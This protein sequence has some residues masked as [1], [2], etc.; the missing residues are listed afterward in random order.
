MDVWEAIKKRR[1]IRKY[2]DKQVP[3]SAI[4]KLIEAARLAPSGCNVQPWK[5]MIVTNESV[6]EKLKMGKAFN[7][8]FVYTAPV[9]I[10]CC[11]DQS[12]Y[13]G[14]T[15]AEYQIMEGSLP[16]NEKTRK[17]WFNFLKQKRDF[18]TVRDITIAASFMILRAEE[19]GLS[20]CFVALI[21]EGIIKDVLKIPK[22]M[23]I[24]YVITV[25]Y[26][27]E[28]PSRRPRKQIN[29]IIR[30]QEGKRVNP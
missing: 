16:R 18:R 8:N 27:A 22:R 5:F 11:G 26:A 23:L 1:S 29:Q 25:G 14:K 9:I 21:R 6:K 20:T 2:K 24:P 12:E 30:L 19:L 17:Q 10:I 3:R 7:Q 28:Y 15:G 13:N 4:R